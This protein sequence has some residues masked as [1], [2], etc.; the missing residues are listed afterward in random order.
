[1]KNNSRLSYL[2]S[3]YFAELKKAEISVPTE[4]RFFLKAEAQAILETHHLQK[5]I[6]YALNE[7]TENTQAE[8]EDIGAMMGVLAHVS[9]ELLT[10]AAAN[11]G[12]LFAK[13]LLVRFNKTVAQSMEVIQHASKSTSA[14]DTL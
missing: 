8:K 6:T 1:M 13:F 3:L 10:F 2:K 9:A 12:E 11:H 14:I 5:Q 7:F 4:E